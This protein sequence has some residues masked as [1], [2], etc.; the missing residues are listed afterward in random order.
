MSRQEKYFTVD[1]G[2][3]L[4]NITVDRLKAFIELP[5]LPSCEPLNREISETSVSGVNNANTA[6]GYSHP[7]D[8]RQGPRP[9]YAAMNG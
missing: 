9:D 6:P 1:Y 2:S 3:C 5:S 7:Y 4:D 8:T